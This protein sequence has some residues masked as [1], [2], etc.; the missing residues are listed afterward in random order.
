[1]PVSDLKFAQPA[2][3]NLLAPVLL[4]FLIL[5][6]TLALVMRFTPH[7]TADLDILH[8]NVYSAHTVFKGES[9]LVGHDR[10]QDDLY[11]LTTLRITDGL[12][13]PLFLKDFTAT[14]TTGDGEEI[15]TSA[16]EKDDLPSVLSAFPALKPL[17]SEPLLRE[18]MINPG[19]S[20]EGMI[21]LHFPISQEVWDHR[22]TAALNVDL[23]HQGLQSIMISRASEAVPNPATKVAN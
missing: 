8:T 3:S 18:T 5:G 9:I 20:A 7:K 2:R 12:R 11:V 1:M 14:L 4:A 22:R 19:Q 10:G 16:V 15:T 13:L 6:I 21:I 23:Y 17:A